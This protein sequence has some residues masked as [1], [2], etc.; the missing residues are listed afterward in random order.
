[1]TLPSVSIIAPVFNDEKLIKLLID[2]LLVQKYPKQ[3]YEIIIVDNGSKDKTK[4]IVRQYPVVLLEENEIQSSYAARNK[5]IAKAKGEILAF[6]D[7]DCIANPDWLSEGVRALD[8]ADLVGGRV[9]FYF[10]PKKTAAEYYD[11]LIHFHFEDTIRDRKVTGAGNLFVRASTFKKIGLFPHVASGG[12]FQWTGR[13]TASGLS[14]I[15]S[16]TTVIQHPARTFKDLIKKH[17][18]TGGG[19]P[20][21]WQTQKE[22]LWKWSHFFSLLS[23]PAFSSIKKL[24]AERGKPQMNEK[25]W[26][27]WGVCY[28]CKI[29]FLMGILSSVFK[30][31]L[32][33]NKS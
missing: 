19:K 5:A 25:Y 31:S 13:A 11:S 17:Q 6:I 32:S 12:D 10:S 28:V 23:P 22:S 1:M 20:Y 33:G 30:I 29:V 27:I 8:K 4:D 9:E 14:L 26:S 15:Y 18:R 24:I 3:L 7:S 16:P 2:S 21:V